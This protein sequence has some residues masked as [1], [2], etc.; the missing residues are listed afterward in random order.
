MATN[1]GSTIAVAATS[2]SDADDEPIEPDSA[3]SA[4]ETEEIGTATVM[5]T[6][7]CES[8]TGELLNV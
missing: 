2:I 8:K 7:I 3:D 5:Y 1:L 6:L 4:T